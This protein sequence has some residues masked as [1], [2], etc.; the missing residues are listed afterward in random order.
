M[1]LK[2]LLEPIMNR[3]FNMQERLFRLF[4]TL[5]LISYSLSVLRGIIIGANKINLC[6][7]ILA[8]FVLLSLA[9]CSIR[10]HKTQIMSVIIAA[11][12]VFVILP[13]NFITSGGT[14]S[15]SPMWFVLVVVYICLNVHGKLK[16]FFFGSLAV[17]V[18]G[19]YFVDY[20]YPDLIIGYSRTTACSDSILTVFVVSVVIAIMILFQN[21]I[22]Q[23]ENNFANKQKKEIEE[24]N[25]A[26]NRFFSSMSHE[27]RTPINTIIGL[28]EM[29][30]REDIS[31]E[32]AEDAKNIQNASK[33]LLTLI[34]DILD[35]SKIESGNMDIVPVNY[36]LGGMLSDIVNMIWVKA[37]E[38]GLEFH[39]NVDE[40]TPAKLYGDEVRIKQI[41]I[42]VL[43]NAVKYTSEGS[44]TLSIQCDETHDGKINMIYSIADTGIGIKKESLPYLFSAFKRVDEERN[45]HIEGTGL[46]LSIVK[47]LVELMDG[48]ITVNS[49]YTKGSTFVITL[50]QG[51]SGETCIGKIDLDAKSDITKREHYKQSFEAPDA[52]VL[53]V[54]DNEMNLMV[55]KKLLAD[56]LVKVKTVT[57]GAEC[58]RETA[59]IKYNVI[60]MDHMMPEMDGIECFHAIRKQ[61][62]MLNIDTPIVI[63]TANAGSENRNLYERE[64]FDGYLLKPISGKQLEMELLRH[65]PRELVKI[66]HDKETVDSNDVLFVHKSKI[67][68]LVTTES[69]CDLPSNLIEKYR[70][71]VIP[72]HI[73][74]EE[75]D[76]MEG[77]E[78]E[79]DELISYIENSG[80]SV[81]AEAPK[82]SEYEDFFADNL[83]RAQH[84]IHITLAKNVANGGYDN[85]CEAAETFDNVHIIDSGQLSTSIGLIV[86]RTAEYVE[87]G[88]HTP[89][90][91]ADFVKSLKERASTIFML[92]TTDFLVRSGRFSPVMSK[93][94]NAF[95]LYPMLSMKNSKISFTG[96]MF[97]SK[98]Y[99]RKK[100]IKRL[101]KNKKT[102]DKKLLFITHIGLSDEELQE[103]EEETLSIVP[104]EK[105]I[106]CQTSSVIALNGGRG[107]FGLLFLRMGGLEE[108]KY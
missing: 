106:C 59:R 12:I 44:V 28:N 43:N 86:L 94:C 87:E 2:K 39:V 26:Q 56:T 67:P 45:R 8:F 20:F 76:F 107:C 52:N 89:E 65:L 75:G 19:C 84:I 21:K 36:D 27:I 83:T 80:K 101:L 17:V 23:S 34:N 1:K 58:L 104:F 38:K 9:I 81:H 102:I 98:D 97:G 16:Y 53:I 37:N 25:K 60:F 49:I 31:D 6:F 54:D 51:V 57:S 32:V 47:S 30:L 105:V 10:F 13:I 90:E 82:I 88:N 61:S 85:A 103:I 100:Y 66:I 64:G 18:C 4:A 14:Y 73:H 72:H 42:N 92:E 71:P 70:I 11:I 22:Y 91:V 55:A 96:L 63:L 93:L 41:L 24:L 29:I 50:P 33:M 68:I 74:T 35:M 7:V 62:E 77:V 108:S 79:T 5:A 15:G 99:R 40:K 48:Q 95:S 3:N 69:V 78:I 46:G